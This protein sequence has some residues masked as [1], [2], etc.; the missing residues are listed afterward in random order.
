MCSSQNKPI[1]T[2]GQGTEIKPI[3]KSLPA[4]IEH[5]ELSPTVQGSFSHGLWA[6]CEVSSAGPTSWGSEHE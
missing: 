5:E 2:I 3:A 4:I 1:K 6:N